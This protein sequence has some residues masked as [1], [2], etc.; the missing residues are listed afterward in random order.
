MTL[1]RVRRIESRGDE[2]WRRGL[3]VIG[4][5]G[6]Q[7]VVEVSAIEHPVH[8]VRTDDQP[9]TG[10]DLV[11]RNV[12]LGVLLGAEDVGEDVAHG[13]R[14]DPRGISAEVLS[15]HRHGPRVVLRQLCQRLAAAQV[16]TA[17]ADV[18]DHDTVGAEEQRDE[19]AS[20]PGV[21]VVVLRDAKHPSIRQVDGRAQAIGVV[22]EL[23]VDAVRPGE[24]RLPMGMANE[25]DQRLEGQ[26]GCDFTGVAPA[27]AVGHG[28]EAEVGFEHERVFVDTPHRSRIGMASR[29][30][31]ERGG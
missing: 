7:R 21:V 22:G 11:L 6:K 3:D 15:Q 26:P 18:S 13:M 4:R 27:H 1:S 12:D 24:V 17:I 14:G 9:V 31:D 25:T 20:H 8:P 28:E 23:G 16:G 30:E 2:A 5:S 19:R 10:L 29:A